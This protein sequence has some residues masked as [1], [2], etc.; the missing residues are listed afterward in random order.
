MKEFVVIGLGSFGWSLATQL[1]KSGGQVLAIDANESRINAICD[2]VT[3]AVVADATDAQMLSKLLPRDPDAVIVALSSH[4]EAS[5]MITL[6][7]KELGI[8]RIYAKASSSDH[9]KVLVR[10]GVTDVIHPERD[11]AAHLSDRLLHPNML[12]NLQLDDDHSIM[13]I[14]APTSFFGKTL[15][16]LQLPKQYQILILAVKESAPD[17][18]HIIPAA[19]TIIKKDAALILVGRTHSL[20]KIQELK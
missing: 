7:L 20:E 13:E 18:L 9:A 1:Q 19:D 16:E 14:V 2:A 6:H 5:I 17:Q 10:L 11:M 15:A 12:E 4:V 8:Q 3:Q